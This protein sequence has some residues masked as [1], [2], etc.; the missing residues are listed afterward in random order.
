MPCTFCDSFL[1]ICI[2]WA[3][4]RSPLHHWWEASSGPPP[5]AKIYAAVPLQTEAARIDSRLTDGCHKAAAARRPKRGG[6]R[7]SLLAFVVPAPN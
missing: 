4:N 5:A 7:A 2:R 6:R 1:N 3:I